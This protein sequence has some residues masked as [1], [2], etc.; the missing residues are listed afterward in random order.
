MRLSEPLGQWK[1]TRVDRDGNEEAIYQ[2]SFD[3]TKRMIALVC[4]PR[5]M[6]Y[7]K[8]SEREDI[9]S[10]KAFMA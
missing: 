2:S 7:I 5:T 8:E 9:A 10:P 3:G 1:V 6:A 4:L